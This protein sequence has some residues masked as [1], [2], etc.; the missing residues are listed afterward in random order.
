MTDLEKL[1][2][3]HC[4]FQEVQNDI[5]DDHMIAQALSFVEDIREPL[6]QEHMQQQLDNLQK[7]VTLLGSHAF[8]SAPSDDECDEIDSMP[9]TEPERDL[10]L[11]F[12][13]DFATGSLSKAEES[14]K[15]I[16]KLKD[17]I[18]QETEDQSLAL[19]RE[20]RKMNINPQTFGKENS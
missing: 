13:Y 9:L 18:L 14:V 4:T 19:D 17:D 7:Q 1:E 12:G 3:I 6:L 15:R 5:I 2:Y 8:P 16:S 11:Q 20:L 10:A